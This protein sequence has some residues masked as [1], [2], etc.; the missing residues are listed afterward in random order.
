MDQS[1]ISPKIKEAMDDA[2]YTLL[3]S[4]PVSYTHLP[5]RLKAQTEWTEQ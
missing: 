2:F 5:R 4:V 3:R 1:N